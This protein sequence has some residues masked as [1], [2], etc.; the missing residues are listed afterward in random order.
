[1]TRSIAWFLAKLMVV[2]LSLT[3]VWMEWGRRAY[4]RFF[5]E[6]SNP[7]YALFDITAYQGGVRE[8][9][10]NYI[11]F[12]V[13][14]I[15]TPRISSMR[16]IGGILG[17]VLLIF[18]FQLAFNIWVEFAYPIQ[19]S[20]RGGGFAVYLPAILMADALPLILWVTICHEFVSDVIYRAF[21]SWD[22]NRSK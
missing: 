1:M 14:M 21:E 8:R 20:A 15:V 4:G 16:R 3:W 13:L 19:S 5:V 22:V 11:P 10:I 17:G 18:G 9:Y 6:V 7:V 12:L 2:S